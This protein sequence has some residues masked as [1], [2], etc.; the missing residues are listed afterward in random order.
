MAAEIVHQCENGATSR[1]VHDS[2]VTSL[3]QYKNMPVSKVRT[4]EDMPISRQ[5]LVI[6]VTGAHT[7]IKTCQSAGDWR[8]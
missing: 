3:Q 5:V 8:L 7:S 1:R 4:S 6:A 2:T